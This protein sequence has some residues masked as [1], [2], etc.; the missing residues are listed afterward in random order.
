MKK[1]PTRERIK[2]YLQ[3]GKKLTSLKAFEKFNTFSLQQHIN[4][5]RKQGIDIIT[6]IKE[7]KNTK[8]KFAEYSIKG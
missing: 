4:A 8:T 3:S 7:N 2:K 1:T 6:E 5:L